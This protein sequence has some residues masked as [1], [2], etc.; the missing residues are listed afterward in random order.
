[1][2]KNNETVKPTSVIISKEA[3]RR[4]HTFALENDLKKAKALEELIKRGVKV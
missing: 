1:M 3:K 2:K 4:W